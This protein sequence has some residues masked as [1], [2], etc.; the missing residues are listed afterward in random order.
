MRGCLGPS[1]RQVERERQ[2][3]GRRE[4]AQGGGLF[5]VTWP[6]LIAAAG[7]QLTP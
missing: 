4:G 2:E 3:G 5:T 6:L 1:R 7:F